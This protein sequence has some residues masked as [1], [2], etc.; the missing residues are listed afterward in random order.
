M[1]YQL[2]RKLV[3]MFTLFTVITIVTLFV[4]NAIAGNTIHNSLLWNLFLGFVPLLI[5]AGIV[6]IQDKLNNFWLFVAGGVWLLFYPNAPYIISDFIHVR[7]DQPAVAVYDTLIIF[8]FAMLSF[9]YGL[10]SMKMAWVVLV[11]RFSRNIANAIIV[12][13][14]VMASLGLYLGR[15]IRLNSWDLFTKPLGIFKEIWASLFPVADHWQAYA[16]IF[17]FL[18]AQSLVLLATKNFE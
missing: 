13:S 5:A 16:M 2:D 3:L 7:S 4:R 8:L 9:Y 10:Y 15:V 12:F 6:F 1:H 11:K 14:L 17:L 18:M